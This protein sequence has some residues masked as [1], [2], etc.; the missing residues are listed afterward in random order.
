M[1]PGKCEPLSLSYHC[2]KFGAYR[3]CGIGDE[4]FLI[5]HVISCDT[6]IQDRIT[7]RVGGIH[8]NSPLHQ[9]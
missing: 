8:R 3:S 9:V 4:K 5:C 6:V 2:P 1:R 7:L